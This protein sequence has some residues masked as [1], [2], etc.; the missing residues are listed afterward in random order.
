MGNE[1]DLKRL[2]TTTS[3]ILDNASTSLQNCSLDLTTD[4]HATRMHFSPDYS[5]H[6]PMEFFFPI[7]F[8]IEKYR[9]EDLQED[10]RGL[11][12]SRMKRKVEVFSI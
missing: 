2:D 1:H 11:D 8:R 9:K 5:H 12:L 4:F 10:F 7:L 6:F 3:Y